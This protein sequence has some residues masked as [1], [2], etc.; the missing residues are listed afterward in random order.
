MVGTWKVAMLQWVLK[1]NFY[2]KSYISSNIQVYIEFPTVAVLVTLI[3]KL[4]FPGGAV[5]KN[6]P[7]NAGDERDAD[8]IP[9]LGRFPGEGNDNPFHYYCLENFMDRGELQFMGSQKSWT[10]LSMSTSIRVCL[11]SILKLKQPGIHRYPFVVHSIIESWSESNP[12]EGNGNT[13]QYSCLG[14]PMDR[15]AWRATILGV[16]KSLAW[17][18]NWTTT[19]TCGSEI[20]S[21][22]IQAVI[23]NL[24]STGWLKPQTFL[25]VLEA[26]KSKIKLPSDS[27]SGED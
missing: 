12:G 11:A 7:S 6:P 18:S 20:L 5:V 23:T 24:P 4:G 1:D 17:L 14:N 26:G 25:T 21:W 22:L 27:V 15:G 9:W 8:L 16:V 3:S 19:T 10:W 2:I 13:L